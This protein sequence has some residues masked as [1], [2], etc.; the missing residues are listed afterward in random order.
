M[1]KIH[2][3]S[4][5]ACFQDRCICAE[6]AQENKLL[7]AFW[8]VEAKTACNLHVGQQMASQT[9][10]LHR[11]P[12]TGP[13]VSRV[14]IFSLK[15]VLRDT[16]QMQVS[17]QK[18]CHNLFLHQHSIYFHPTH[19]R[20]QSGISYFIIYLISCI[21]VTFYFALANSSLLCNIP[22]PVTCPLSGRHHSSL[23]GFIYSSSVCPRPHSSHLLLSAPAIHCVT[24]FC[25]AIHCL[26]LC[27]MRLYC[28]PLPYALLHCVTLY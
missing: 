27:Y 4:T 11:W 14:W 16:R 3:I 12:N 5:S 13:S 21:I 17:S 2:F 26:E 20:Q 15:L 9:S 28:I 22:V 23:S 18:I 1:T 24:L 6:S 10:I 19:I 8:A 25:T 7:K